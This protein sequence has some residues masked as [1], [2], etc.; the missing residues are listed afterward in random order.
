[1]HQV[2]DAVKYIKKLRP[3]PDI[4]FNQE[5]EI[6]YI[7]PDAYVISAGGTCRMVLSDSFQPE[8]CIN[9]Y[10]ARL[11]NETDDLEVRKYLQEKMEK[12]KELKLELLKRKSTSLRCMEV[13]VSEQMDYFT[14]AS[15]LPTKLEQNTVAR[16]LNLHKSTVSRTLSGKYVQTESGVYPIKFFFPKSAEVGGE[17]TVTYVKQRIR[18]TIESE[19]ESAPLT[20]QHLSERLSRHGIDISRRTVTKYRMDMGIPGVLERRRSFT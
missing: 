11:L 13:I 19:D 17:K 18:L 5:D 14:G 16:T 20:D 8:I 1:M 6:C 9:P 4:S 3:L 10:Y 15:K 2:E 12:A 7:S